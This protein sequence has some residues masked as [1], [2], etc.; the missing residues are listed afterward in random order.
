MKW[1]S[2][3]LAALLL[4]NVCIAQF[5]FGNTMEGSEQLEAYIGVQC[6]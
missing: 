5:P 6:E 4:N 1:E 2:V 3:A